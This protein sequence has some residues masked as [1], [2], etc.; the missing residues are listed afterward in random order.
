MAIIKSQYELSDEDVLRLWYWAKEL[1]LPP[2]NPLDEEKRKAAV[3]QKFKEDFE[4]YVQIAFNQ[5]VEYGK[6]N[7]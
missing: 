6:R 4:R 3:Y 5:G 1:A 2:V 7:P